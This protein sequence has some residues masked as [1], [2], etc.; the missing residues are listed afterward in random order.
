VLKFAS[1][2]R[3]WE[4]RA[5]LQSFAPLLA[6][7]CLAPGSARAQAQSQPAAQAQTQSA[8]SARKVISQVDPAYPPDLKRALIGGVVRLDV[9][10][11]AHG[12]VDY[13]QVAGGNPI[14]ADAAVK[15]VKQWKY[16]PAAATTNIRV[17]VHFDPTH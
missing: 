11:N 2:R 6:C 16:A 9:V 12:V 5:L 15:A 1:F 3:P 14:L 13:V 10:V 8:K 7:L 4:S 17:N